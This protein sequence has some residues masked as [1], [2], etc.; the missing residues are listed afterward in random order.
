MDTTLYHSQAMPN[1]K[2]VAE[3]LQW[4]EAEFTQA[5][6]WFGHGTTNA[7]DEAVYLVLH[8]LQLPPTTGNEILSRELTEAERQA[9]QQLFERRLSQH[10]P[11]PYLTKQAWFASLNF[12]VDERVLIPRSSLGEL[13]EQQFEPWL[14]AEPKTILEIGTG[15]GCIAIAC[16]HYFP[17]AKMTATDISSDALAVAKI[18][19][20][21]HQMQERVKLIQADVWQ[22]LPNK[23]YDLI[24]SN[25]PYVSLKEMSDLPKEYR[26]EPTI[27]LL[28]D[29]NGLAIVINILQKAADYLT[30]DGVLVV[31]V[32]NSDGVLQAK[33]PQVPFMWLEFEESEGGVFL[34]TAAELNK[35]QQDFLNVR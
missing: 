25:P 17:E 26:H 4:A 6:L 29:Q 15:S 3:C 1:W 18:N 23:K 19:I 8:A 31:E 7:W 13:I 2:T 30:D 33:F 20:D 32:G 11:A 27:A 22:G 14:P 35:Y 24:V 34:L 21:K 28:A 5:Q 16:A 10:I 12:Y 9:I